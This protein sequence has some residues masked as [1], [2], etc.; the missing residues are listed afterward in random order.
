MTSPADTKFGSQSI[1]VVKADRQE[2]GIVV[3]ISLGVWKTLI[4]DAILE[5]S[6]KMTIT[7]R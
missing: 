2:A 5:Q 7:K 1:S 3:G 6:K 4:H